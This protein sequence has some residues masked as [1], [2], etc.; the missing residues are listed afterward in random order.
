MDKLFDLM[1]M[2]AKYCLVCSAKL[3]DMVEVLFAASHGLLTD[4]HSEARCPYDVPCAMSCITKQH[5]GTLCP[6][7]YMQ[8]WLLVSSQAGALHCLPSQQHP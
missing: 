3:E 5:H 7:R 2:G 4:C 6:I 8:Q 1:V